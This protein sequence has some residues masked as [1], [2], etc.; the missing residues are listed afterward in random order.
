MDLRK[1]IYGHCVS[2][3]KVQIWDAYSS[4]YVTRLVPCGKC[5]HCKNTHINEWCTRLIAQRKYSKFCY[6]VSLDYA[7]FDEA[8]SVAMQLAK[9]TAAC[10]NDCN[11]THHYGLHPL[12]LCKNHLQDFY[13]RLRKNTNIKLQYFA[14]G[15][16]GMHAN[17]HGYGRPHFH[18]IV[19]SNEPLTSDDFR[20]A[21]SIDDYVIGRVDFVDMSLAGLGDND[22]IKIYKY[23]CKYLQKSDFD[24]SKLATID[25][26][27][28]YFKSLQYVLAKTDTLFPESVPITDKTTLDENWREYIK[29]YSPFVVCSRRPSIGSAYLVE[30]LERF[31][32]QDFRLFGL[33]KECSAFPRYYVRRAKESLNPFQC[34]GRDSQKPTTCS[35]LGYITQVLVDL[36][37]IRTDLDLWRED[38]P[39]PWCVYNNKA[40]GGRL[41]IK[42][43]KWSQSILCSDLSFYDR[44]NKFMYQF[45]GYEYNVWAKLANNS[46][47]L[48]DCMDICDVLHE[49]KPSWDRYHKTYLSPL[50]RKRVMQEIELQDIVSALF[51]ATQDK[52]SVERFRDEIWRV[53]KTELATMYKTKLL[54]QNSKTTL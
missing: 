8:S 10:Y 39:R 2:P 51:P 1:Y 35:R 3:V 25:F 12:V 15:E 40:K 53:Y 29:L 19:F 44:Q 41:C 38:A 33:P 27:R 24:F 21:W 52:T 34:I 46:Y 43:S 14:C 31:K 42:S 9:E 17:G 13:K 4:Q 32:D 49:I 20:K 5:L 37:D 22:S 45:N 54:M 7:P 16:Y 30:N 28:A 26:H 36:Q 50:E 48:L 6:Y 47:A 18:N 11:K 23:V